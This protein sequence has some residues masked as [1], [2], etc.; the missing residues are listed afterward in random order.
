MVAVSLLWLIST[1]Y[2]V[3]PFV[4]YLEVGNL[5]GLS[6]LVALFVVVTAGC[7]IG[8]FVEL[9]VNMARL[10]N[11][12]RARVA[13][14]NVPCQPPAEVPG[15]LSAA[16][17]LRKKKEKKL[18]RTMLI[19]VGILG[20]CYLPGILAY[21]LSAQKTDQ[22]ERN[23]IVQR[24]CDTSFYLNSFINPFWYCWRIGHLRR[25]VQKL[26]GLRQR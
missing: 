18:A 5:V 14:A 12:R 24:W 11:R 23:W 2:T 26:L 3:L 16:A 22:V 7:Y 10:N 4:G 13:P 9:D 20:L 15:Q 1:V 6:V 21:S 25:T 8:T 17:S 19:T